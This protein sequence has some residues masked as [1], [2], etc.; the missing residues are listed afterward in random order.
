MYNVENS[1][2]L[3]HI[4]THLVTSGKGEFSN[5][6]GETTRSGLVHV[7]S[8]STMYPHLVK[9]LL[10]DNFL[11]S[12][13]LCP[14]LLLP[15]L[16]WLRLLKS[17]L[18]LLVSSVPCDKLRR[19]CGCSL[20]VVRLGSKIEPKLAAVL[21]AVVVAAAVLLLLCR[22]VEVTRGEEFA[23]L[24]SLVMWWVLGF[25]WEG[26][27]GP[28]VLRLGISSS[29]LKCRSRCPDLVGCS[30]FSISPL[31]SLLKLPPARSHSCPWDSTSSSLSNAPAVSSALMAQTLK[32]YMFSFDALSLFF[33][34]KRSQC[35]C[36][37]SNMYVLHKRKKTQIRHSGLF[38]LSFPGC[39]R[40]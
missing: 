31:L 12:L 32:K 37:N 21:F 5:S 35:A 15:G 20:F 22:E 19:K 17:V 6:S 39:D 27:G 10:A 3:L 36:A 2:C 8:T 38:Q 25:V 9:S 29:A 30:K 7:A 4:F 24:L 28:G 1:H 11:G 13:L 14:V 26:E 16:W 23:K 33:F 40:H 18:S 34:K